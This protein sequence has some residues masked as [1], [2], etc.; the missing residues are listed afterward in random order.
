MIF[1]LDNKTWIVILYV[2]PH[3]ALTF[4]HDFDY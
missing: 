4:W 3:I 2:I 1:M